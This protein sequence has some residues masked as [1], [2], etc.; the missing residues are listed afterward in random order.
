MKFIIAIEFIIF[1]Y[2]LI[3]LTIS[4]SMLLL[5][6]CNLRQRLSGSTFQG[7]LLAIGGIVGRR[8]EMLGRFAAR[9]YLDTVLRGILR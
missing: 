6:F 1:K 7:A 2:L 3:I 9:T 4:L 5:E 8:A